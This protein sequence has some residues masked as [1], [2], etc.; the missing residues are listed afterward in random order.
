MKIAISTDGDFVSAHFGRCPAFTVIEI[1]NGK[2]VRK[3]LL[4]NPGHEPGVIPQFLSQKGA[5]CIVCGGMGGRAVGLFN[6]L[7]IKVVTGITGR[8]AEVITELEQ[9]NLQGGPSLCQPGAGR[10][11]GVA[12]N[13]CD[14][15]HEA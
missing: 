13:E 9:G 6:E 15:T 11:Y 8:I 10:G 2:T 12:K 5:E 14:H 1:V 7:N 3:E 4:P